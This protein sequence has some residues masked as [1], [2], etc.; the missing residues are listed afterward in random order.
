MP[1][2][3]SPTATEIQ[4]AVED[5]LRL[6]HD[7][8]EHNMLWVYEDLM[9]GR[10]PRVCPLILSRGQTASEI[11]HST[12]AGAWGLAPPE[13]VL[14]DSLRGIPRALASGNLYTP[15]LG[16]CFGTATVASA[17]G[18]ELDLGNPLN[19]GGVKA[20]LPL[21]TFDGAGVPD[22]N[23]AGCFPTIRERL[24]C[25]HAHT[26]PEIKFGLADLQGPLNNA[27]MIRGTELFIAM[28]TE[29]DRLHHLL[30]L[31]TDFMISAFATLRAWIGPDRLV[32]FIRD[33]NCLRECSVNL[34]SRADYREFALPYDRQIVAALGE[35]ALHP[36]SG[37]HVFEETL[38]GLSNVRFS[39][40]G[41][42]SA[43]FAPCVTLDDALAETAG[44]P[45]ILRGLEDLLSG[46]PEAPIKDHFARLDDHDLMMF[47]YST[48]H[49][50]PAQEPEL[51]A[52]R[53][54]FDDYYDDR[55]AI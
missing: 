27:H 38:R 34:I 32:P 19:P 14:L 41:V 9:A 47:T 20:Y 46:D 31:I 45:L 24:E 53:R 12:P 7:C 15:V 37:L 54:R 48:G 28:R 50:T 2:A 35:I 26:P 49:Y 52:L 55:Y 40:W 36:C 22:V 25:Y 6:L 3:E 1:P 23:T 44:R 17:F 4:S 13:Q 33:T 11:A 5:V 18:C 42:V 29:P 8:P 21:S 51:I 43:A 16:S 10:R 39:E 30:Q